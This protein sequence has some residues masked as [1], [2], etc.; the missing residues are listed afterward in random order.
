LLEQ[1][2]GV[3]LCS[4]SINSTAGYDIDEINEFCVLHP[5]I[6]FFEWVEEKYLRHFLLKK[7]DSRANGLLVLG[8]LNKHQIDIMYDALD[9]SDIPLFACEY[10]DLHGIPANDNAYIKLLIN[11]YVAKI[12]N[13]LDAAKQ[14]SP[15]GLVKMFESIDRPAMNRRQFLKMPLKLGK[16]EEVPVIDDKK[17]IASVSS[18]QLCV[19]ACPTQSLI[20]TNGS[21]FIK[22]EKCLKCGWCSVSCPY[23]SIHIPTFTVPAGKALIDN[24]SP[25]IEINEKTTL[26]FSCTAG[27]EEIKKI[28]FTMPDGNPYIMVRVPCLASISYLHLIKAVQAGFNR[29]I[30]LCPHKN[31]TR[32]ASLLKWRTMFLF[33]KQLLETSELNSPL[34]LCSMEN[35]ESV[36]R[37]FKNNQHNYL[38]SYISE[39]NNTLV[40][41]D[42]ISYK[43]EF[44]E[45]LNNL[46]KYSPIRDE[47]HYDSALPFYR[48][49]ID[50][51]SCSMCGSCWEKCPSHALSI[52]NAT[53]GDLIVFDYIKCIGCRTCIDN[54]AEKSLT[55][56]KVL[57]FKNID[58]HIK[59]LLKHDELVICKGCQKPIGNRSLLKKVNQDLVEK[60]WM[61]N[62]DKIY[63]CSD[64]QFTEIKNDLQNYLLQVAKPPGQ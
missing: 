20:K 17:C 42:G 56:V 48:I 30:M 35:L 8:K 1:K 53:L 28:S 51:E 45:L 44:A 43:E 31:C 4:N 38:N 11:A 15:V 59:E 50:A 10:A 47:S 12:L 64:C 14:A 54:C 41:D 7:M 61:N 57:D 5:N 26:L 52:E 16:Y 18:C 33:I 32:Q 55:I 49:S 19:D 40:S 23:N 25:A 39:N 46:L 27:C 2:F 60:G 6:A 37:E 22:N 58:N 24:L 62:A 36:S 9:S 21:I 29:I 3:L 34:V 13:G 63:Y